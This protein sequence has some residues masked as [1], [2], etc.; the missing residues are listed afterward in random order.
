MSQ[1]IIFI[2]HG[3]GPLPLLGD[4][5]HAAMV[6]YLQKLASRLP[7]PKAILVISAHWEVSVPTVT[8]SA[9]PSLEYDYYGFADEAYQIAYPCPGAPT[10]AGE[11][12]DVLTASGFN[13]GQNSERGL[14]HGV[15]VPLKIMYP[16]ADIPV[17]QLSLMQN[18]NAAEHIATGEALRGLRQEGLLVIGS[19]FSFHNMREFFSG[20]HLSSQKNAAF[21]T[22]LEDICTNPDYAESERLESLRQWQ[23]A[24]YAQFCHPRAEHL[25]PLMVCAGLA[26][27]RA[28]AYSGVPIL[29]KS[30]AMI[31]W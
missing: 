24:P 21:E 1:N 9:N 18:L 4:S 14:D 26:N 25:M 31:E 27:Q 28:S 8:A 7:K 29:G 20:S 16:Q 13:T 22:W 2:S 15:F 23:S 12:A 5:G 3:G 11:V 17:V 6:G 10:L 19:G 30:A